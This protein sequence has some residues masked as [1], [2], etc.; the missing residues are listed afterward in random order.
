MAEG[1]KTPFDQTF[2]TNRV[3]YREGITTA[4]SSPS[5]NGIPEI[6]LDV[7][8][9]RMNQQPKYGGVAAPAGDRIVQ[10]ASAQRAYNGH[11]ELYVWFTPSTDEEDCAPVNP[12]L[13]DGVL[14]DD[15][16]RCHATLRVWAW[17]GEHDVDPVVGPLPDADNLNEELSSSSLSDNFGRWCLYHEQSVVVDTL[18]ALRNIPANRYRVTVDF[19]S[20]NSEVDILE[21]HTE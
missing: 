17:G 5:D 14:Q 18:I 10:R 19:I 11:L 20:P 3:A 13:V 21:Q 9:D 6:R 8:M 15:D 4:D 16:D 2:L 1:R 12:G 7:E